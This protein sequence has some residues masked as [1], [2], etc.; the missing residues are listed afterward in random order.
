[1]HSVH[2]KKTQ[3]KM[4]ELNWK[5]KISYFFQM[6]SS[7]S[8]SNREL[9]SCLGTPVFHFAPTFIHNVNTFECTQWHYNMQNEN[10]GWL[11]INAHPKI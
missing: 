5:C 11:F 8:N 1:M 2:G 9:R 3:K 7:I 4:L 6:K 10:L